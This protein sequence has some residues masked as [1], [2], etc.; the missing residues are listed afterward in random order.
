MTAMVLALLAIAF[1]VMPLIELYVIIQVGSAIG[2]WNTIGILILVALVGVWLTKHEGFYVLQ[3]MRQQLDAG[4]MPTDE[5]IDGCLILT[6]GLLLILPGFISDAFGLVVL[7]PPTRS[8]IRNVR[9]APAPHH[10]D[11]P[12]QR[13]SLRRRSRRP[14]VGPAG[15]RRVAR[16]SRARRNTSRANHT[17]DTGSARARAASPI[18]TRSRSSTGH[19]L[20]PVQ[21]RR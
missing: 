3:R 7:F 5:L 4:N 19:R 16:V 15:H 8:L 2:A 12:L 9:E 14:A 10:D 11:P 6:G 17:P 13:P 20:V 18:R 1:I 21:T